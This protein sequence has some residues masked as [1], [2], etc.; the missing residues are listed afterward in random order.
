MRTIPFYVVD[1]FTTEP[2]QGNP[3]GVFLDAAGLS[4]DEMRR[5]AGEVHLESAFV[6][7]VA[8]GDGDG[9]HDFRLRY[10]TGVT[11]VPLCGHAT[12]AAVTVLAQTGRVAA[13]ASLGFLTNVGTIGAECAA[14]DDG[15]L[16]VTQ[17]QRAPEFGGPL[18]PGAVAAALGLRPEA[19]AETGLPVRVVSTGTSWLYAPVGSREAVDA[20][21]ASFEAIADLSRQTGTYGVYA[22]AV[23]AEQ[24]G[25]GGAVRVWSRCF[26]PI[27]GLNEDPVTGSASGALGAYL[28]AAGVLPK[29]GGVVETRQGFA[30]G[31]GGKVRI[32]VTADAGAVTRVA[33]TGTATVLAEGAFTL[34]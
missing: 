4:A 23:E 8:E 30:G 33:V 5:L 1:S 20:S 12:L 27:A 18:A 22:F 2:F 34:P 6:L 3:A 14:G 10:F 11:E 9:G 26:A 13:D 21:P 25:E 17:I 15:R 16:T 28:W 19:I 31:R 32:E 29:T 24:P 7:P